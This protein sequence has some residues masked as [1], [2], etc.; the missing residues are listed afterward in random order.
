MLALVVLSCAMLAA[1]G[2]D[3]EPIVYAPSL[4][5]TTWVYSEYHGDGSTETW[6]ISFSGSSATLRYAVKEGTEEYSTTFNYTYTSDESDTKSATIVAMRP[7]QAG[8]ATLEGRIEGFMKMTV[9]NMSK[10]E[11]VGIFYRQ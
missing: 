7:V 1:C 2:S 6:T 3:S 4:S 5:G 11:E 9:V 8:N 10:N